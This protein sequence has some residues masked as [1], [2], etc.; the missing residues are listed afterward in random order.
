MIGKYKID[1]LMYK[2]LKELSNKFYY[3]RELGERVKL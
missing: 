3:L 1:I 2:D